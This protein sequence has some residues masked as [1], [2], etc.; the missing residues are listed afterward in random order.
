MNDFY[1]SQS[2]YGHFT[3][4]KAQIAMGFEK[5]RK[6]NVGDIAPDGYQL[7]NIDG[8]LRW[9]KPKLEGKAISYN[10]V[11]SGE[12]KLKSANLDIDKTKPQEKTK[13]SE[14][15]SDKETFED[16]KNRNR[17][18]DKFKDAPDGQFVQIGNKFYVKVGDFFWYEA[19]TNNEI[20]PLKMEKMLSPEDFGTEITPK[21]K[22]QKRKYKVKE[23]RLKDAQTDYNLTRKEAAKLINSKPYALK[24]I[25]ELD[26]ELLNIFSNNKKNM[27]NYY[28]IRRVEDLRVSKHTDIVPYEKSEKALKRFVLKDKKEIASR[29]T[30]SNIYHDAG[31]DVAT[32]GHKMIVVPTERETAEPLK[33]PNGEELRFPNWKAVIPDADYGEPTN[34]EISINS[35]LEKLKKI[36][37]EFILFQ[38]SE[39]DEKA[40]LHLDNLRTALQAFNDM[41]IKT[42]KVTLRPI[43]ASVVKSKNGVIA[44]IMPV[45]IADDEDF[46]NEKVETVII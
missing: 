34:M 10:A 25:D 14:F 4:Q 24:T 8:V 16:F 46:R 32:D 21:D 41:G 17:F 5:G 3:I 12:D 9:R 11:K 13:N 36:K 1:K 45:E 29:P 6:W 18:Y 28:N 23:Q 33:S 2:L 7:Q 44:I 31:F 40:G 19:G 35:E 30:L 26:T 27:A 42:A 37:K 22:E 20:T 38:D 43:G 15:A 39:G